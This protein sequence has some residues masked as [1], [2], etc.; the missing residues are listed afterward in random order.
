MKTATRLFTAAA[1][2]VLPV[3]AF[4]QADAHHPA[5]GAGTPSAAAP[6]PASA[7]G[8][9]ADQTQNMMQMM[10]QM[11][12]MMQQM[13]QMMEMM[14]Q[15]QTMQ[16][17]M[18]MGMPGGQGGP[19]GMGM[20]AGPAGTSMTGMSAAGKAYMSAMAGMNGPMMQATQIADP[21]V[22]FVKGM[23]AHHQG[24][25]DMAKAVLQ[26]GK[27]EQVKTWA[28]QIIKAQEAEKAEMES[29]LKQHGQ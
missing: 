13:M 18:M 12:P 1:L 14:Q 10:G 24:A 7:P 4:A 3:T 20:P 11:M 25:I 17:G 26:Y 2:M 21:D 6:A 15:K 23:V 16:G 29:W 5:T 28:N 8:A 27:D 9:P 22:A 19:G